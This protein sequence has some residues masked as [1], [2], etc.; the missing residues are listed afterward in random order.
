MSRTIRW[1]I[2]G[3]GRIARNFAE[4]LRDAKGAVAS[5]AGSR[6]RESAESFSDEL[7]IPH[8]YATYE[9]LCASTEVDVIYVATPHPLHASCTRMALERGKHVL[10]EKPFAINRREAESMV[11]LARGKGLFLMEAMWTRF[12]PIMAQVRAWVA[13]GAIGEVRM[14][15]ADFGFRT[16]ADETSRLLDPALAGGSLLDVGIYPVS[17]ASM[18]Y[19][20]QP[21]SIAS[22]ATMSPQGIDEQCA[23]A[24]KY[25]NGELALLSS[26][27]RT[28]TPLEARIMGSDGMIHIHPPF[29]KPSKATL[30][31][32]DQADQTVEIPVGGNGMNYEAEAVTNDI[33]AGRTENALMPLDESLAIMGTLDAIRGQWGMKYPME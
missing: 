4:G 2:L 19:G 23:I 29:Y 33:L 24:F 18:V 7:G 5:A 8:R 12:F 10:C 21:E 9:A 26:A 22:A 30:S 13:D 11:A 6:T 17:F 3:T 32:P 28:D 1:G 27:V 31:R 16:D 14:V 25:A 15:S 20:R